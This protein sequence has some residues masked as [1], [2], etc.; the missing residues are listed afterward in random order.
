MLTSLF[1]LFYVT[2]KCRSFYTK[3]EPTEI[4]ESKT[5]KIGTRKQE[6]CLSQYHS[7]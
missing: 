1:S 6:K 4:K 7:R 3:D 5:K 2:G